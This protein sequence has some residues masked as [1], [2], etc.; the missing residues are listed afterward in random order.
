MKALVIGADSLGNIPQLLAAYDIDISRHITGRNAS[1]KRKPSSLPKGTDL[2]ILFT[3]FL[4]HN[5][6]HNF[7]ALAQARG[8]PVVACCRSVCAVEAQLTSSGLRR[9]PTDDCTERRR[10]LN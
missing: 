3:D 5:V 8:V 10:R 6:M 2:M 4:G 1:H 9:C 7:K